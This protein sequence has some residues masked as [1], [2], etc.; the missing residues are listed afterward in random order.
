M[1]VLFSFSSRL[2][3]RTRLPTRGVLSIAL[4][5]LNALPPSAPSP[6]ISKYVRFLTTPQSSPTPVYVGPLSKPIRLLKIFSMTTAAL[7]VSLSPVLVYF[8][9]PATPLVARVAMSTIVLM[10][11]VSTTLL[12]HW[13]VKSY[14]TRMYYDRGSGQVR[15]FTFD[16]IGREKES[17]F[18]VSETAPPTKATSLSTFQAKDRVYY[19]HANIFDD[20]DLLLKLA[21]PDVFFG[22]SPRH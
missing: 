19:L 10:A 2:C 17:I 8:G 3:S 7:T 13:F 14:I 9:N 18:H 16:M 22:E 21:G 6:P 20:I 4:R 15:A 12:L 5:S 1:R 11:G